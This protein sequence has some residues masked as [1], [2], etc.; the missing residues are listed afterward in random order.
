MR[1]IHGPTQ[2]S[3]YRGGRRPDPFPTQA[4]APA[5]LGDVLCDLFSFFTGLHGDG[6]WRSHLCMSSFSHDINCIKG[7]LL[8]TGPTV[9]GLL[10]PPVL[11]NPS[12]CSEIYIHT[13]GVGCL[14]NRPAVG[15]CGR[16][17][18][19]VRAVEDV[20]VDYVVCRIVSQPFDLWYG[21]VC[22]ELV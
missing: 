11:L 8:C 14:P 19:K 6:T 3:L 9:S 5:V 1:S 4:V 15:Y 17:N 22:L 20:A 2:L 13:L 18:L 10:P 12:P 7:N 16:R 21:D